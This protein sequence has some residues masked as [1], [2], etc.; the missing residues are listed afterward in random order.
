MNF[1]KTEINSAWNIG[2]FLNSRFGSL[3]FIQY[4]P[5]V[6][7]HTHFQGREFL[8]FIPHSLR[9]WHLR[10]RRD[11]KRVNT[12][13]WSEGT[14][15]LTVSSW[16]TVTTAIK[17]F[18]AN[19]LKERRYDLEDLTELGLPLGNGLRAERPRKRAPLMAS[20]ITGSTEK[21][22]TPFLRLTMLPISSLRDPKNS[23]SGWSRERVISIPGLYPKWPTFGPAVASVILKLV[24][25]RQKNNR[26]KIEGTWDTSCREWILFKQALADAPKDF[27]ERER[28][29]AVEGFYAETGAWDKEELDLLII[30]FGVSYLLRSDR[31]FSTEGTLES[32]EPEEGLCLWLPEILRYSNLRPLRLQSQNTRIYVSSGSKAVKEEHDSERLSWPI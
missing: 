22:P 27:R 2:K 31:L 13:G 3:Y 16:N 7:K 4:W 29:Q 21:D 28:R 9:S 14:W 12:E 17:F 23:I 1:E 20:R 10:G 18:R 24:S 11:S 19:F 5:K 8:L 6:W 26:A 32:P 25:T 30:F 15:G